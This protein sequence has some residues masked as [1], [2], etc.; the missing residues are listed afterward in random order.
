VKRSLLLVSALVVV[1]ACETSTDPLDGI[2]NGG[3]GAISPDEATGTWTFTLQR[4][5]TF[6]CTGALASG[7]SITAFFDVLADGT[8]S[9]TSSWQNPISSVAEPLSGTVGLTNGALRLTFD[10]TSGA[11][12]DLSTGTMNAS[13]TVT[14]ATITDPAPGSFQVFGSDACQ[15]SATAVKAG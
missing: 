15:Y 6:P 14:A 7:Q 5:T 8:L 9:S 3:G 4:T 1:A 11:A 2:I 10:A 12:M 13:G